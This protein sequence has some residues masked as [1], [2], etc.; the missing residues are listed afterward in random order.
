MSKRIERKSLNTKG[1]ILDIAEDLFV[2]YNYSAVSMSE[3]A[4]R[5]KITKAALYY[6]FK[7]KQ[8]LYFHILEEA[9]KDFI[10]ELSEVINSKQSL[11]RRFHLLIVTYLNFCFKK[12]DLSRL[13]MQR[14]TKKDKKIIIFLKQLKDKIVRQ[15]E[16]IVEEVL[17][18]SGKR[19][20]D[21]LFATY[22]LIGILN[23]FVTVN[24]IR[25]SGK[26]STEQI[27]N[28]IKLLVFSKL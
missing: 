26:W 14:L 18:S 24:I 10:K 25:N 28:Q 12:R 21:C 3:I 17:R 15:L 9:F 19:K 6:H 8:D 11:D 1:Q 5:A 27:A 7:S 4:K 22:S 13:M 20:V 16:P 2:K 23:T